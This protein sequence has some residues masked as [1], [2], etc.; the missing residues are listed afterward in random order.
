MQ[1][2]VEETTGGMHPGLLVA[3]CILLGVP[4]AG[5][6]AERGHRSL[7]AVLGAADLERELALLA[8]AELSEKRTSAACTCDGAGWQRRRV[9]AENPVQATV[10]DGDAVCVLPGGSCFPRRLRGVPRTSKMSAKSASRR[11]CSSNETSS[12]E[13]LWARSRW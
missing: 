11:N 5:D 13:K 7:V 2:A 6:V 8:R 12:A 10:R 1:P 4:P 9:R 3:E